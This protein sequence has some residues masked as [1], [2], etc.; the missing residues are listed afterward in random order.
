[1][2]AQLEKEIAT[3]LEAELRAFYAETNAKHAHISVELALFTDL[4]D[5]LQPDASPRIEWAFYQAGHG[6]HKG[7]TFGI[8]LEAATR[9]NS[10]AAKIA[11]AEAHEKEAAELRRAAQC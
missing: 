6:I 3:A 8:A 5:K 11:L 2:T 4:K 7:Q 9:A 1:M 10:A